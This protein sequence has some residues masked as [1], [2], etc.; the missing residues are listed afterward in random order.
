MS[1]NSRSEA[2]QIWID[3]SKEKIFEVKNRVEQI[4][5]S[6][7]HLD[8]MVVEYCPLDTV[9]KFNHETN[10]HEFYSYYQSG[11]DDLLKIAE[12]LLP[13]GPVI[14]ETKNSVEKTANQL[15]KKKEGIANKIVG[16]FSAI[17]ALLG[18]LPLGEV[19]THFTISL[20]IKIL[21]IV[22]VPQREGLH[23]FFS[24]KKYKYILITMR[25]FL[26][27][28]VAAS[29]AID[30][31][32][33]GASF[34]AALNG[35]VPL[36]VLLLAATAIPGAALTAGCTAYI[37]MSAKNQLLQTSLQDP[38]VK[39]PSGGLSYEPQRIIE[40]KEFFMLLK[41]R[42]IINE[43]KEFKELTERLKL[44]NLVLVEGTEELF[45]ALS[46]QNYQLRVSDR[47][48][49]EIAEWFKKN[50]NHPV[51]IDFHF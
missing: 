18:A 12:Q 46:Y 4:M 24:S 30:L 22:C 39:L 40:P 32:G 29:F 36:S 13:L 10:Q 37:G 43:T 35:V 42:Y 15:Q 11:V 38:T 5:K 1:N 3:K 45:T 19:A 50:P 34:L 7:K 31:A 25:T 2:P 9:I 17:N 33:A 20:M 27:G 8:N 44:H 48:R 6:K 16:I 21:V 26:T 49:E 41:K 47:I 28:S 51:S 14:E 23:Q